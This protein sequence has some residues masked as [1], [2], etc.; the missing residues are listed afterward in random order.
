MIMKI[1][2]RFKEYVKKADD[3]TPE[4]A[5]DILIEIYINACGSSLGERTVARYAADFW[6]WRYREEHPKLPEK[7]NFRDVM[8]LRSEEYRRNKENIDKYTCGCTDPREIIRISV[9]MLDD[10]EDENTRIAL[11]SG[12]FWFLSYLAE[13]AMSRNN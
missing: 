4:A 7:M 5:L 10:Y 3:I 8:E 9:E 1:D 2:P 6:I 11:C 13:Q 12:I